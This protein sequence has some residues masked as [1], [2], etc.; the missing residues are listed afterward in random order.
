VLWLLSPRWLLLHVATL[1]AL[2]LTVVL[3]Q[4][5][6]TAYAARERQEQQA[7]A[8]AA[9]ATEPVPIDSV[10]AAGEPLTRP[11]LGT[12][13]SVTGEFADEATLALPGRRLDD[14]DG[15]YVVTPVRDDAGALTPVLRGWVPS[16][17]APGLA[18]PAGEVTVTG[19]VAETET[20]ADAQVDPR[21]A[22]PAGQ[23]A[24]LSS[25]VLFQSYPVAP[26]QIRQALVVAVDET[27]SSPEPPA[28]VSVEQAVPALG[29][30]AA[31]RHLSYAWQW[32]LFGAAAIV[33][34]VAFV[35]AGFRDRREPDV[36]AVAP[37]SAA[38]GRTVG[39]D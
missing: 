37:T 24:A 30:V 11:A 12:L 17:E 23:V 28:R 15:W 39:G 13:V 34:W 33:F 2:A 21:T 18:A 16:L 10:V 27:P 29:G 22:L 25:T 36:D 26:A 35:R 20:D 9:L 19:V 3:G 14:R 7:A 6:M 5:Q 38:A 31:W 1:G 8:A 32:W 4:W